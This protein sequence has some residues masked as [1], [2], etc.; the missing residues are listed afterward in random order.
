MILAFLGLI[1][2]YILWILLVR[3]FLWKLILGV[4][5]WFGIYMF[6]I[7]Y[8]SGAGDTG[9]IISETLISWAAVIPTIIVMLAMAH[10]KEE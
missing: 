1:A 2:I 4:G 3:G 10:I 9:I 5:G 7:T 6:L 8:V